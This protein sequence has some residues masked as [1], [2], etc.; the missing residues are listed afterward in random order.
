ML[1]WRPGAPVKVA[2]KGR[3]MGL[4]TLL[5]ALLGWAVGICAAHASERVDIPNGEVTLHAT[6]FRP[7]GD[8]PFKAV[9]AMH[10]CGGLVRRPATLS[11]LYPE[12][13]NRL[14][15]DGFV[16]LF[17]DSFA[18]RGLGSQ[19]REQQ[20]KIHASRERVAD[21]NAARQWLQGQSYIQGDRI[22]LLGW[23]NG[24]SATLWAVRPTA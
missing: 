3:R 17:P 10:D 21:A 9:V 2:N 15:G 14:V 20:R 24:G 8:G 23:S 6:L 11:H 19:C 5:V 22:S 12:W 7:E 4:R 16:V 18:S 13:A 1:C